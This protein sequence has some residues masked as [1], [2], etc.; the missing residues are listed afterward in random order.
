MNKTHK[1]IKAQRTRLMLDLAVR[2]LDGAITP[3]RHHAMCDRVN[4]AYNNTWRSYANAAV[5]Q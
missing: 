5:N 2:R 3:E 1:E 4:Q